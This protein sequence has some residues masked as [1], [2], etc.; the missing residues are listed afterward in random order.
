MLEIIDHKKLSPE[1]S[2][3]SRSVISGRAR[4]SGNY[5][6]LQMQLHGFTGKCWRSGCDCL[7]PHVR[8]R[9]FGYGTDPK[10]YV[11]KSDWAIMVFVS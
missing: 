5:L 9:K 8:R 3:D 7:E 1:I 6:N 4:L 10:R 2:E 11:N